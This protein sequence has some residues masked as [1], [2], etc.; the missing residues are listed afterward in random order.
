M[1]SKINVGRIV[2]D[3]IFTL[4]NEKADSISK[5]DII[6]MFALPAA[7]GV[8]FE[9]MD[10]IINRD[11]VGILVSIFAILAGLLFNVLVLMYSISKSILDIPI[12]QK[13]DRERLLSQAFAN[14]SYAVLISL[15][16]VCLL[17]VT[18][19]VPN[20]VSSYINIVIVFLAVNFVLTVLM[21][22]KRLYVLFG[23]RLD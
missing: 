7:I 16:V 3:H 5:S 20:W 21:I 15:I 18:L 14:V 19:I 22:L 23:V 6:L 10:L 4:R 13:E 11:D 1:S 17:G 2:V 12:S 9:W 8:A